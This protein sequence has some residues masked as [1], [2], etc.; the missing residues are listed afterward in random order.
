MRVLLTEGSGLTSRQVATRLGELGHDVELLSSRALCL[1]RFT[2]HVRRVHRVP[3][4]GPGPLA[5]FEE[6][7]AIAVRRK[8]DVLFPTQEQVTVLSARRTRLPVRTIVPQFAALRRVQGKITAYE[9]LRDCGVPQPPS[10]VIRQPSE[11]AR[12]SPSFPVFVK[13]AVSTASSGVRKVHDTEALREA[14]AE[15]A[16]E[17]AVLVQAQVEGQLLM[18]Q[19]VADQGRLLAL[20]ANLRVREGAGGGA[21]AK[22]SVVDARLRAPIESLVAHLAWHGPISFDVIVAPHGPQFIDVN[23]RLVEPRNAL[24]A[25]VD[26]VALSL[27]LACGDHPTPQG[28]GREGVRTHQ[29]LLAELTAAAEGRR[30]LLR[31]VTQALLRRG[32]YDGSAEELTPARGDLLAALVPALVAGGAL[33]A[34]RLAAT[35][36]RTSVGAYALTEGGWAEVLRAA[37]EAERGAQG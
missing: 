4:F 30:A 14:V 31:E 26:L 17:D 33:L 22:R 32:P 5:W 24:L 3:E 13:R 35:L 9:T 34:P 2:R 10:W 21:S 23:P 12:V 37:S 20:H 18:V 36:T 16:H 28:E 7:C 11:I 29:L 1:G 6:A 8:V 27:A 19:A 15:L 25:G